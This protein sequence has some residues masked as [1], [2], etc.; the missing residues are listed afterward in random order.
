MRIKPN[1]DAPYIIG[2]DLGGT[3]VRAVL[4]DRSGNILQ[5]ARRPTLATEPPPVIEGQIVGAVRDAMARAGVSEQDVAGV[6]IGIPGI[7]D[8]ETGVVFWS[9][10]F[11]TWSDAEPVGANV[12]K[13]LGLATYIINDA[14]CA[15]LGELHFGA[16][17]GAR[18]MVMITLGTG[19]GGAIVLDGKLM[20][21]PQ[22]S[23]GEIGH[24][25]LWPDG[26]KCG[27]GNFGCMEA[28]CG[29]GAIVDRCRR[30]LQAGRYSRIIELVGGDWEKITPAIIDQAADEGDPVAREVMEE[31][32]MWIGIGAA[33]MINILAPDLFVIGGGVAQAGETIFE[34]IIRT[35]NA[36]AVR[37]QRERCRVVPAELGDNAGVMGGVVLVLQALEAEK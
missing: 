34:P 10:N 3:N 5:D 6:G 33:N 12:A 24:Q 9:P 2:V 14:R 21:G 29:I 30:K 25:T 18:N 1:K 15:A 27:C 31:T 7:M 11:P 8:H 35:I 19:I 23:I 20:L 13:Q 28:L 36:R 32:G 22:G 16:G 37:R 4:S 26:P 17:R